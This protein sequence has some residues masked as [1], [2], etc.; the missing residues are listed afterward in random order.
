[1]Q[2]TVHVKQNNSPLSPVRKALYALGIIVM[3]FLFLLC[4]HFAVYTHIYSGSASFANSLVNF[5]GLLF[6]LLLFIFCMISGFENGPK[7]WIFDFMVFYTYIYLTVSLMALMLDGIVRFIPLN[8]ALYTFTYA[9]ASVY[10]L[11]FWFYQ[12]EVDVSNSTRRF[13]NV[14]VY[15]L[16]AAYILASI[17]NVKTG[18][19]FTIEQHNGRI[20]YTI[21][22]IFSIV[23][24]LLTLGFYALRI[25][26]AR[27]PRKKKWSLASYVL[28]PAL[29]VPTSFLI[30]RISPGLMIDSLSGIAYVL[31]L[32]IIFFNI[33]L[34]QK[35][36]LIRQNARETELKTAT[37][38]SQ[39]QPHFIY[40]SL[41]TIS[42]LCKKDPMLAKEA[43]DKFADYLRMNLDAPDSEHLIP[44]SKE[45]EHI[46]TY[47]WLEKL[48]FG[49]SLNVEYDI[50][51]TDFLIPSLTVQPLVE[52][53]VKHGIRGVEGGG[54]VTVSTKKLTS[55]VRITVSDDG[56][57]FDISLKKQDGKNHVGLE[58]VTMRLK[59]LCNGI[60]TVKSRIGKGTACNILIPMEGENERNTR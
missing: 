34:E 3:V 45:L 6:L 28:I 52:N 47:L 29:L 40:N 48:R 50:Q 38:L 58:N 32:Y 56:A 11:L 12:K 46:R 17:L 55:G 20:K 39:I 15:V 43:T 5:I 31:T 36:E 41:A 53:A 30:D 10:W 35:N 37:M 19:M 21:P 44:F 16:A 26:T 9:G 4:M 2:K 33:H 24:T 51:F 42:H 13:F 22:D 23:M 54:T 8:Y 14:I 25:L 49:D 7:N 57:G 18:M 60:L 59:N 27:C 1:M